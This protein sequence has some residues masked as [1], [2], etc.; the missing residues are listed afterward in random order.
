MRVNVR[1]LSAAGFAALSVGLGVSVLSA[2]AA[3]AASAVAHPNSVVYDQAGTST[4]LTGTNLPSAL[5]F[6]MHLPANSHCTFPGSSGEQ[7]WS[8]AVPEGTDL[9]TLTFKN[10]P[11]QADQGTSPIHSNGSYPPQSNAQNSPVG[12]I[13]AT[14]LLGLQWAQE[15]SSTGGGLTVQGTQLP[16]GTA[17]IPTGS[18][19]A[20]YE[21]GVA[22]TA[23]AGNTGGF[24]ANAVTDYWSIPVIFTVSGA[25]GCTDPN[26]FCWTPFAPPPPNVAEAPLAIGLPLGAAALFAG[27]V[28]INRRRRRGTGLPVAV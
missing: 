13:D 1:S 6:D 21:V 2:S 4:Q 23:G 15:V 16:A 25:N 17:L 26:G 18:N 19:T 27:A 8:F 3:F 20:Q 28:Y 10:F 22:C 12:G 11:P 14:Y 9:T 5:N 24:A 7:Y